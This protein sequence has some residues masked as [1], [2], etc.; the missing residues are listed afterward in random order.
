MGDEQPDRRYLQ[1]LARGL[2]VLR[3]FRTDDGPIGNRE[4]AN[5]TGLPKSTI[6]RLTYTLA[7]YGFIEHIESLDKFRLGLAALTLGNVAFANQPFMG[8]AQR[9]MQGFVAEHGLAVYLVSRADNQ[10]LI[11]HCWWPTAANASAS[12]GVIEP[13]VSIF[14]VSLS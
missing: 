3:A 11:R 4:L 12:S 10:M 1:T 13:S 14:R 9:I 5:R 7:Q 2:D 8:P 6:T